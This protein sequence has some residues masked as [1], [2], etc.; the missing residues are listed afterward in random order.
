MIWIETPTYAVFEFQKKHKDE[1]IKMVQRWIEEHFVEKVDF[2][3][4]AKENGMS[5]RTF[6]RR[7]KSATGDTPLLYLQRTRVET[8]RRLL[9]GQFLTFDE[10]CHR[11][12]Y[13]NSNSFRE[14]FR[15][16]TG[17]LPMEYQK[18][19]RIYPEPMKGLGSAAR[20]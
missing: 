12:G 7:F 6:E 19:F 10:I 14:V 11:L 18:K 1:K 8:A 17:L 20:P 16:H 9:E 2:D 13:E 4:V 5:R 15:K 3:E